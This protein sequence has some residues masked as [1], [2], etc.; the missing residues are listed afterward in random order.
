MDQNENL[1]IK[2]IIDIKINSVKG[3]F[4]DFILYIIL[5]IINSKVFCPDF[6]KKFIKRKD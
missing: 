5:L 3:I 2:N 4:I 6:I 1:N